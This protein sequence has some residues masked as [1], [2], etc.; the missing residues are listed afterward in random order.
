MQT[1]NKQDVKTTVVPIPPNAAKLI[2]SLR[3]VGYDNYSEM[4]DLIDN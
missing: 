1:Q 4:M 2:E 3:H